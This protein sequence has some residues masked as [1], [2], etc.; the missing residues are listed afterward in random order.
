MLGSLVLMLPGVQTRMVR[1]ITN[2]LSADLN[3][4]ISIGRV[5]VTPFTGIRLRDFLVLDQQKDTL[6]YAASLRA[7]IDRFSWRHQHLYLGSVRFDQ[8][9]VHLYQHDDKMN[10]SFLLDSLGQNRPDTVLWQYSVRGINIENGT[11]DFAHNILQNPGLAADELHF[12]NLKLNIR[13]TSEPGAPLSFEVV[14]F[15][16]REAT[17]LRIDGFR[18][19]GYLASD[20]IVIDQLSFRTMRSL[21]DFQA[22]ELPLGQTEVEGYDVPFRGSINKL[23][24]DPEDIRHYFP[25]FPPLESP[26]SFSGEIFGSLDQLKGRNIQA[27]FGSHSALHTSFDISGLSNFNEAFLYMDIEKLETSIPDLELLIVGEQAAIPESFRQLETIRYKGTITGFI[28]NLVAYGAF[29]SALGSINTDIGIKM[30]EE[31]FLFGG[32]LN[33]S[34]FNLGRMINADPALGRVSLDMEVSGSRS[35][36]TDYFVILDGTAEEL[37]FNDYHYHD[38][39]VQGLLT[40]Q[41]FDGNVRLND[42]NGALDFIGTVDMSGRVAHFD[43]MAAIRNAQLDR[44][45]LVPGMKDGVLS[46]VLETNFQGNNLDDLVGEIVLREGLLYTPA[47]GLD[48]DSISVRAERLGDQKQLTLRSAYADGE[49]T[50]KYLFRHFRRTAM[51]FIQHYLPAY[52]D[53]GTPAASTPDNDFSFDLRLKKMHQVLAVFLPEINMADQGHLQG[54]F[55]SEPPSLELDLEMDH[56]GYNK[57]ESSEIRVR[58]R[59][60]ESD[61]LSLVTR[62]GNLRMGKLADLYNFSVHQRAQNDSLRTN[63]FWNNWDLETYSG[64]IYSTTHFTRDADQER[65]TAIHLQPSSILV[66]D[67][68]W[69]ISESQLTFYKKGMSVRDFRIQHQNQFVHLHGF[70]H[71]EVPDGLQ[72]LF[73]QLNVDQFLQPKADSKIS[74]GGTINGELS[75]SD[76]YRDPLLTS[77]L[78]IQDFMFNQTRYGTLSLESR[79]NNEAN[80]LLVG[81][82]I[83]HQGHEPLT[84]SGLFHP[85]NQQLDFHFDLDRLSVGF[86]DPFI[87]KVMQ[88][89]EGYASGRMYLKGPLSRPYLT[90]SVALHDGRFGVDLLKTA[91]Q[92]RDSVTFYPNEMRFRNMLV[93]DRHNRSGRFNGSIYHNGGFK[94]LNFNLRITANNMLMLNTRRQ[95]NPYYYGTVYGTGNLNINGMLDNINLTINGRTQPNTR[96]FIPIRSTETALETNFIRFVGNN[97]SSSDPNGN[98]AA[99]QTPDYSVDLTGLELEMNIEATP[100]AEVQI[101]FDERIG[102]ILK[103]TGNGNLQIRIDR[104]GNLRFFGD[105]TIQQGEYLFSLQN[106]INKQFVINQG[107]TVEWQGD[108]YNAEIDITA[109]Y[110]LRASLS[111]LLD[112]VTST[113]SSAEQNELQRRVQIHTNLMLSGPLQQPNIRFGIEMP[114]LDESR[115]ALVLDYISSE[116]E[117]NRQVLSLLVLNRFYTPEHMRMNDQS[118]QRG[119]NAALVTTTEMLSAQVSRWM[120]SISNDFDFGVAYRPGDNITSEEFEMAVSTQFFNNRVTV[121]GNVGVGKYQTNTSKMVGDFDLDVK[122][123]PSG[124]L[125]AR[126]Y[127]RSNEDLIYE[128]SPTTQG[129]GLSFREEFDH[130]G[131]LIKKYWRALAGKK[132]DEE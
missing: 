102:D 34:D 51:G 40:H 105:Y 35:S 56:L 103:S 11:L 100:D 60:N 71:R 86:L 75:L 31:R 3:T 12:Q 115:E 9:E 69:Q 79:W 21:F 43:F 1:S 117:L 6:F 59:A 26:F 22:I 15:S 112:P 107:G 68:L 4:E 61:G 7:G 73:N 108:P 74:F 93:S 131:Q 91:Y 46:V 55:R 38:I 49:I 50:G 87:V 66:A 94:D 77:N 54:H 98:G 24:I 97:N 65:H 13:R 30:E 113:G 57:F 19:T 41:K 128:T 36:K 10:F 89:I 39:T 124:T 125:R 84:G 58:A 5:S 70:L 110:K 45:N 120:S 122:L 18:S 29:S 118:S 2:R 92:V 47:I 96:F 127:T 101:I 78:Q 42:P 76:F 80:A 17:G 20:K 130:I 123:N 83:D 126:A 95:D 32:L 121:N 53:K 109:V 52:V 37:E 25:A 106:L 14:H 104:Q 28:N 132:E 72:L 90:G 64:A 62:A 33:T 67:S 114:T 111:D 99:V 129:I 48:F 85:E 119:E 27:S 8:P 82:R 44:L 81:T 63:I 23:I 16:L 116:E 88:D